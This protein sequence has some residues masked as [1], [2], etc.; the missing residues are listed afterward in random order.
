[1]GLNVHVVNGLAP[2]VPI[3][4]TYRG[5]L[6]FLASDALRMALVLAL[7]STALWLVDVLV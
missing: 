3:A 5:V 7:P 4:E 6:P 2:D 1:V